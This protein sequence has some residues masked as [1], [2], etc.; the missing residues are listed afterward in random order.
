M[1]L[2]WLG[3]IGVG[4]VPPLEVVFR[5]PSRLLFLL[6][7]PLPRLIGLLKGLF[8]RPLARI[9]VRLFSLHACI[10][11]F[12][13]AWPFELGMLAVASFITLKALIDVTV[14][15]VTARTARI[16]AIKRKWSFIIGS[17][18][19]QITSLA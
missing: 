2:M 10:P 19:T 12:T 4:L 6:H 16:D 17:S 15:N 9:I 7:G 11:Y 5:K 3:L 1:D 8:V 14:C 13:I 18:E